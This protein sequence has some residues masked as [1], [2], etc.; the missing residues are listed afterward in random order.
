MGAS[1][2]HAKG[3]RSVVVGKIKELTAK[4]SVTYFF[5]G[6]CEPAKKGVV[7]ELV[8]DKSDTQSAWNY[9]GKCCFK[10]G[11]VTRLKDGKGMA[12]VGYQQ[13]LI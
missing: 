12:Y 4:F 11:K 10:C 9:Q 2:A 6:E 1:I 3:I 5:C 8:S 7:W 13:S